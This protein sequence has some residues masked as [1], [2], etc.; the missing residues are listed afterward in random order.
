VLVV[1]TGE[2]MTT[3]SRSVGTFSGGAAASAM[4]VESPLQ[5]RTSKVS[6]YEYIGGAFQTQHQLEDQIS[7]EEV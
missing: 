2:S 5:V 6:S 3:C 4:S 7:R 1:L